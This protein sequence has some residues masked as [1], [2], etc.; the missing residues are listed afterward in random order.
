MA[1]DSKKKP[2]PWAKS[3]AKFY[4]REDVISGII[5]KNMKAKDVYNMRP[6][7]KEYKYENFRNNL[8]SL[9]KAVKRDLGRAELDKEY[10]QHDKHLFRGDSNLN[11]KAWHR[12]DAYNILKEDIKGGRVEGMKPKEIYNSRREYQ[13]FSLKKVR[14]QIYVEQERLRKKKLIE[15]GTHPRFGRLRHDPRKKKVKSTEVK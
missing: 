13:A 9:R 2:I 11:S 10:Y 15:L 7:Y 8:L 3:D 1:K 12:S 5:S 6:Q 4:L 14:I